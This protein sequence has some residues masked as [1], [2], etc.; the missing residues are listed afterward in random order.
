MLM[1]HT[2]PSDIVQS[3]EQLAH[4]PVLTTTTTKEPDCD[5]KKARK[6]RGWVIFR[7][8]EE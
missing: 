5:A 2:I 6:K 4:I 7:Q 1:G 8:L 3:F